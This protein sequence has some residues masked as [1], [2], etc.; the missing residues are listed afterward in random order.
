MLPLKDPT[1][2]KQACYLGGHWACADTGSTI[3]VTNPATAEILGCVP[4]MGTEE[5]RRAIRAAQA[6]LPGWRAKTAKER[7][8]ILR[9]WFELIMANQEDLAVIM[10]AVRGGTGEDAAAL[11]AATIPI[12]R[13]MTPDPTPDGTYR[14]AITQGY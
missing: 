5:T 8:I 11:G 9:R 14:S 13:A 12:Y 2:L 3:N 10:T 7:S 6:A 4:K 1:L